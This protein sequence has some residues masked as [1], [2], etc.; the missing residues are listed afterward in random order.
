[1]LLFFS[2]SCLE[3]LRRLF[4][5]D[6]G[7]ITAAAVTGPAKQPL[8]ASSVPHSKLKDEYCILSLKMLKFEQ[9]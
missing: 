1:M 8:P 7:K 6:V 4:L 2:E 5:N 9:S 3:S